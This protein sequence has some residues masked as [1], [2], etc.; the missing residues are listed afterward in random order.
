MYSLR[1]S[2]LTATSRTPAIHRLASIASHVRPA[3]RLLRTMAS[4]PKTMKGVQ[5]SKTGGVDVLEYKTDIPVPTLKEGE[6]LVKNEFAGVNYSTTPL[7]SHS[8]SH[9][10]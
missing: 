6:I 2:L 4:L 5:I 9:T 3:P 10:N 7:I 8:P 1:H